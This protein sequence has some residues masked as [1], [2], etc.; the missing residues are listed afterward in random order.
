[1]R[2]RDPAEEMLE[3]GFGCVK[4]VD[5]FAVSM[6]GNRPYSPHQ[7]SILLWVAQSQQLT[8]SKWKDVRLQAAVQGQSFTIP[9][10]SGVPTTS[11]RQITLFWGYSLTS[12]LLLACRQWP[13]L[14]V[15]HLQERFQ[16]RANLWGRHSC[17]A[18]SC[19]K[20]SAQLPRQ[21]RNK[22]DNIC[23]ASL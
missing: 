15:L 10:I 14:H 13:K 22:C 1:M 18:C 17:N 23:W 7:N 19:D 8:A 5:S 3:M 21:Y 2:G 16:N 12:T 6:S 4:L 20:S 11:T 9:K